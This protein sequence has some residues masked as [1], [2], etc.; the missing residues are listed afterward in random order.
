MTSPTSTA[1]IDELQ[2][3]SDQA[4]G[5]LTVVIETPDLEERYAINKPQVTAVS[6]DQPAKAITSAQ[7]PHCLPW[8]TA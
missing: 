3:L 1:T 8:A 5:I 4:A 6:V 7:Q 2:K